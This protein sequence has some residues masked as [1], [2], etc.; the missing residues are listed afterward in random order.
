M[1]RFSDQQ[2][3]AF[4]IVR[5]RALFTLSHRNLEF[6]GR[7]TNWDPLV[8]LTTLAR[9]EFFISCT[10][11]STAGPYNSERESIS[12]NLLSAQY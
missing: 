4:V 9:E 10:I 5:R 12:K 7:H 1:S 11:A 2:N 6:T 3:Q 8:P